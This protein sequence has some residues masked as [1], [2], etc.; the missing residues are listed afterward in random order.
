MDTGFDSTKNKTNIAKHGVPS[1]LALFLFEGPH[2]AI[3]DDRRNY[4]E[5]RFRAYG[6]VNERLFV[7]VFTMRG[8]AIRVISLRKVNRREQNAY[9][10]S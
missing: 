9:H 2:K 10:Q 3:A 4:G 7:C 1:D 6:V 8:G 5:Q